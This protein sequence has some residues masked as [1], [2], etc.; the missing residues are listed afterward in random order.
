MEVYIGLDLIPRLPF[1][2]HRDNGIPWPNG[3]DVDRSLGISDMA[4][5]GK[6]VCRSRSQKHDDSADI[7]CNSLCSG[8]LV[9]GH[10]AYQ[11]SIR[12]RI[13]NRRV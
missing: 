13:E 3:N 8:D 2:L 6:N 11:D 5:Q 10:S 12:S 4:L 7:T 1:P 9:D